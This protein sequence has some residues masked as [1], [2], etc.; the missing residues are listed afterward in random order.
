[1]YRY[2]QV[3]A[4]ERMVAALAR[5]WRNLLKKNSPEEL[6]L[7]TEFS[8]PALLY[9]LR[10]FKKQAESVDTFTDPIVFRFEDEEIRIPCCDE[11]SV[12]TMTMSVNSSRFSL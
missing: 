11:G 3:G 5:H 8:H 4:R 7:D 6:G 12:S 9:F 1:M 2:E 10:S